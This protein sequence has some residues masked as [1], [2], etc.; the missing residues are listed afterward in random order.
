[1]VQFLL[2]IAGCYSFNSPIYKNTLH[3]ARVD[4]RIDMH[5]LL[6]LQ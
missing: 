4:A 1:M 5:K 6:K 3:D 2:R